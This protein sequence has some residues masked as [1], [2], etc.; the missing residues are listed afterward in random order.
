MAVKNS[1]DALLHLRTLFNVGAIGA[2]SDGQLLE[3]FAT[4][5]GE[6]RELAF[7]ALV[8]G[9]G[10]FVLRPGVVAPIPSLVTRRSV[11]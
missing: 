2:L 6:P 7:A 5:R 11:D 9:H 3:R 10:R 8:E 1:G 4:G